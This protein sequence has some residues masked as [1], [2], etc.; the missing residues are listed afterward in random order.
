[1]DGPIEPTGKHPVRAP[2][3]PEPTHHPTRAEARR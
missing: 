1:M 3:C 2:L